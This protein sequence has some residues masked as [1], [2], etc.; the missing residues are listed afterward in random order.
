MNSEGE[1][2]MYQNIR[3]RRTQTAAR[4]EL[5]LEDNALS[6]SANQSSINGREGRNPS[7]QGFRKESNG[8]KKE[9]LH[10]VPNPH[11]GKS[12]L[13]ES[14]SE[15]FTDPIEINEDAPTPAPADTS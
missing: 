10:Q 7:H 9:K 6:K 5:E 3:V 13:A 8:E 15:P 4:T 11:F 1:E 14:L 12:K 2:I